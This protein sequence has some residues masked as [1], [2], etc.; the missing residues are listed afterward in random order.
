MR[1]MPAPFVDPEDASAAAAIAAIQDDFSYLDDWDAR[2]G[3]IVDLGK[4]LPPFPGEWQTDA[5]KVPG[6]LAQVWMQSSVVDGQVFF[7]GK[8]DAIMVS[9]LIALLLRVYSGR[10]PLEIL[11]TGPEFISELGLDV[12]LTMNRGNGLRA[13]SQ[14]IRSV[15]EQA[16][17]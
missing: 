16:A 4:R 10:P 6:C 12:K 9:G 11:E 14:R 2:F 7:A 15:A 8:S 5:F 13:M 3:H 1:Q 17:A